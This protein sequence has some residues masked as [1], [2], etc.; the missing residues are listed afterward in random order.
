[1]YIIFVIIVRMSSG[2]ISY[3]LLHL[4]CIMHFLNYTIGLAGR[5]GVVENPI[6][7]RVRSLHPG[8]GIDIDLHV[9]AYV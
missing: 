8:C 9:C 6:G 5:G 1:M 7:R 3:I 4:N 2:F